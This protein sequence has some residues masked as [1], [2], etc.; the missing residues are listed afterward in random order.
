MGDVIDIRTHPDWMADACAIC[1][2]TIDRR[3]HRTVTTQNGRVYHERC[4][5]RAGIAECLEDVDET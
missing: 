2:G 3:K 5:L 1:D 4:W